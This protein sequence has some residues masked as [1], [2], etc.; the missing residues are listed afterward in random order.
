MNEV[1]GPV[2]LW[3]TDAVVGALREVLLEELRL[4]A[5][6][7]EHLEQLLKRVEHL[8]EPAIERWTADMIKRYR[9]CMLDPRQPFAVIA[10]YPEDQMR[11]PAISLVI[12]SETE[13]PPESTT[14]VREGRTVQRGTRGRGVDG[15]PRYAYYEPYIYPTVTDIQVTAWAEPDAFARVLANL[16]LGVLR[17]RFGQA[18]EAGVKSLTVTRGALVLPRDPKKPNYVPASFSVRVAWDRVWRQRMAPVPVSISTS[19]GPCGE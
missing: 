17:A 14:H 18:Q 1:T 15:A 3:C 11:I 2:G 5:D 4:L 13:G 19:T 7:E 9:A 6:D 16:A 10:Q 8:R 12:E